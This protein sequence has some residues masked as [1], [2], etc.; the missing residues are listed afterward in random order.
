MRLVDYIVDMMSDRDAFG[1]D[2]QVQYMRRVFARMEI[3]QKTLL[4]RI[5]VEPL[6]ERLRNLR[7]VTLGL[8]E[9]TWITAMR[10]GIIENEEDA[11]LLYLHCLHHTLLTSGIEAPSDAIP[12]NRKMQL[13]VKQVLS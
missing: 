9:K 10:K 7:E 11:A 4:A 6:D 3:A 8:F 5:G 1:H 2:P 12:D 13:F